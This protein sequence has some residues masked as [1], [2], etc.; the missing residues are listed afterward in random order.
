KKSNKILRKKKLKSYYQKTIGQ[1]RNSTGSTIEAILHRQRQNSDGYDL[2][3]PIFSH[4]LLI[5]RAY[6]LWGINIQERKILI[7]PQQTRLIKRV[8][9]FISRVC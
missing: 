9:L 2:S 6:P 8:Y 7:F 5:Q 3:K 1:T 4:H